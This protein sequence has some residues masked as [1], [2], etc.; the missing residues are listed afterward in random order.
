MVSKLCRMADVEPGTRERVIEASP[1]ITAKELVINGSGKRVPGTYV[2]FRPGLAYRTI[3]ASTNTSL[4]T[5][6]NW[7]AR[8]DAAEYARQMSADEVMHLES[9][10]QAIAEWIDEFERHLRKP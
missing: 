8:H 10:V 9:R 2:Q 6:S 1:P 7:I 3:M 4:A 5:F